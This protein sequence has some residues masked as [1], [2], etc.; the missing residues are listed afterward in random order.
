MM[1]YKMSSA[2]FRKGLTGLFVDHPRLLIAAI[3]VF[4]ALVVSGD[5]VAAASAGGSETAVGPNGAGI[6]DPGP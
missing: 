1:D 5:P 6:I 4:A 2:M 3:A